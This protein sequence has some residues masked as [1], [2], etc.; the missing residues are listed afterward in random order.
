MSPSHTEAKTAAAHATLAMAN[1]TQANINATKAKAAG[2]D[3]GVLSPT[4]AAVEETSEALAV[5]MVRLKNTSEE[6][7]LL[8]ERC[9]HALAGAMYAARNLTVF[10]A[11]D[12][13][14]LETE[15]RES[16]IATRK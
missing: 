4:R 8:R 11:E 9:Q 2:V 7:H 12:D 10:L 3:A 14:S 13:G 5:A 15:A 16:A 1:A 6:H